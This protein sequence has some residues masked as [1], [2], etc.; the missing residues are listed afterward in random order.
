MMSMLNLLSRVADATRVPPCPRCAA[1]TEFV[2]EEIL[3]G[4]PPVLESIFRCPR[5]GCDT[6]RC[7]IAS[8][9]D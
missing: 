9:L 5:C 1:A 7:L 2:S 3:P 4:T 8:A 6:V